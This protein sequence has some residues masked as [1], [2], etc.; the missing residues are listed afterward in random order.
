MSVASTPISS[1]PAPSSSITPSRSANIGTKEEANEK[2]SSSSNGQQTSFHSTLSAKTSEKPT[3]ENS[4]TRRKTHLK[5]D[6]TATENTPAKNA[7]QTKKTVTL[8]TIN[9]GESVSSLPKN[10]DSLNF[11]DTNDENPVSDS[12]GNADSGNI[13]L[14]YNNIDISKKN[15]SVGSEDT[16]SG[17]EL[18]TPDNKKNDKDIVIDNVVYVPNIPQ[19]YNKSDK[20]SEEFKNNISS[21]N[22][23]QESKNTDNIESISKENDFHNNSSNNDLIINKEN[24]E[25]IPTE[26]DQK[27]SKNSQLSTPP[28]NYTQKTSQKNEYAEE[29]NNSS[30]EKIANRVDFIL[31]NTDTHQNSKEST[32]LLTQ[33][34]NDPPKYQEK[35]TATR[36]ISSP[37]SS[38]DSIIIEQNDD[39]VLSVKM[40]NSREN[41]PIEIEIS[42]HDQN[43]IT[44]LQ[45]QRDDL[46]QSLGASGIKA[47]SESITFNLMSQSDTDRKEDA[48]PENHILNHESSSWNGNHQGKD[49]QN[50]DQGQ[51]TR[52]AWSGSAW[53]P[54]SDDING[55]SIPKEDSQSTRYNVLGSINITV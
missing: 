24:Q 29:K 25:I 31:T 20:N 27:L 45:E 4:R 12:L 36:E 18:N 16:A 30:S 37:T 15:S 38:T 41:T 22:P 19:E 28:T 40:I 44:A 42:S 49:Q 17:A 48:Y 55:A 13:S 46:I 35:T 7:N 50:P 10:I 23:Y 11:V 5:P 8:A 9:I 32:S 39:S 14:N 34:I 47:S 1:L 54:S 6:L 21:G 53:L 3:S 43:T 26:F 52:L 33:N 51:N 2:V